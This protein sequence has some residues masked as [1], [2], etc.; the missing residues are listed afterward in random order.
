PELIQ[1]PTTKRAI[2]DLLSRVY[3]YEPELVE[4]FLE[5]NQLVNDMG[6]AVKTNIPTETVGDL[7]NYRAAMFWFD[8]FVN[9][10]NPKTL[11]SLIWVFN[12]LGE[13][14]RLETW[15]T[16][17]FQFIVNELYGEPVFA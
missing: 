11:Q 4:N 8:I 15:L 2:I 16:I 3:V 5:V 1:E 17:L 13:C 12:Q 10:G 14:N 6:R 9:K 7:V